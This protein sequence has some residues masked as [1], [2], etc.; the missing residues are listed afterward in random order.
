MR[1]RG[2]DAL[3]D[4]VH[5][6]DRSQ[7][8][9][10]DRHFRGG[11]RPHD[12]SRDRRVTTARRYRLAGPRFPADRPRR[13]RADPGRPH[14]G[15]GRYRA[16]RRAQPLRRDLRDHEGGRDDGAH[17]RSARLRR[18]AT[19][20][21]SAR[22]AISSP[23]AAATI[24]SSSG[25]AARAFQSDLGGEWTAIVYRNKVDGAEA[26]ALQIGRGRSGAA[27]PG[28][29]AQRLRPGRPVGR[30]RARGST[31]CVAR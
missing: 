16:A 15:G 22:S 25:S 13:R 21:R 26:I 3:R 31:C 1:E 12:L 14:R 8:R 24:I 11:S 17:G 10:R 6:L 28:S 9:R 30:A 23:I 18:R 2:R 27:D 7:G 4:R 5:R 19:A 29:H 20:S